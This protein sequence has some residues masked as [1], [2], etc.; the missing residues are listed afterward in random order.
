V[1][2]VVLLSSAAVEDGDAEQ[3]NI[4]ASWHKGLEDAVTRSGLQ[5][6]IVRPGEFANNAAQQW[7]L[8]IRDTG[9]VRAAYGQS[10]SSPIHE[11]DIAAVSMRAL[12]SGEHAGETYVLTGPQSLTRVEMVRI[13]AEVTGRPVRFEEVSRDQELQRLT[14]LGAPGPIIEVVLDIQAASLH[15]E[16]FVSP[17]VEQVTG[18]P[19]LSFAQWATDHV[20]DFV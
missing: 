15:R 2:H 9:V 7:G 11:R 14:G 12:L 10:T 8:Q 1:T 4:L 5:W 19:A 18:R 3:P 16:A 13:L 6:T 17:A 20:A